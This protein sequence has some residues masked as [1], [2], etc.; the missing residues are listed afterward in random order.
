MEE[1]LELVKPY[2][3][4]VVAALVAA[5]V[6]VIRVWVQK[7]AAVKAAEEQERQNGGLPGT[8]KKARAMDKVTNTLPLGVRPLTQAGLDKL[9]EDAVPEARKRASYRPPRK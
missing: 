2:L 9:V 6:T 3:I 8:K 7:W 1:V 5:A 4:E